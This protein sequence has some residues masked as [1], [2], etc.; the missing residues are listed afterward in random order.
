MCYSKKS[1]FI[2]VL[3]T[4]NH[5]KG[6]L[7]FFVDVP[8][9]TTFYQRK[10]YRRKRQK[11]LLWFICAHDLPECANLE[12]M[13]KFRKSFTI[14]VGHKKVPIIVYIKKIKHLN[15]SRYGKRV[16]MELFPRNGSNNYTIIVIYNYSN[17]SMVVRPI[18]KCLLK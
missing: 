1:Y 16:K 14:F 6:G 17:A 2:R 7:M 11:K 13:R 3:S 15:N 10:T 9:Q 8:N 18:P 4:K 5:T 12:F